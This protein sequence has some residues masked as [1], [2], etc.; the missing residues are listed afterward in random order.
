MRISRRA[1]QCLWTC[2]DGE[3]VTLEIDRDIAHGSLVRDALTGHAAAEVEACVASAHPRGIAGGGGGHRRGCA[4]LRWTVS[5]TAMS[6]VHARRGRTHNTKWWW[7]VRGGA[8]KGSRCDGPRMKTR[9]LQ[10]A[11]HDS[12]HGTCALDIYVYG[13]SRPVCV[14]PFSCTAPRSVAGGMGARTRCQASH[15]CTPMQP[16][17]RST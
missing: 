8:G 12:V 3:G 5:D 2:A 6:C 15:A 7:C 13:H 9:L 4:V 17:D 11:C 10:C 1:R 16:S 14:L